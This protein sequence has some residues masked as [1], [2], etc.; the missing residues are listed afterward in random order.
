MADVCPVCGE[1][2]PPGH[3]VVFEDE[4]YVG[5][6]ESEMRLDIWYCNRG[7]RCNPVTAAN[8]LDEVGNAFLNIVGRR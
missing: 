3:E 7:K 2:V 1:I 5:K 8:K 4:R 6:M